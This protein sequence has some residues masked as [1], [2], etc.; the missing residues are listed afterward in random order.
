MLTTSYETFCELAQGVRNA[1]VPVYLER[2]AD[3]ETPVSVLSRFAAD[4]AVASL[5]GSGTVHVASLA[6]PTVG[7]MRGFSGSLTGAGTVTV[8][9][10]ATLDRSRVSVAD[11]LTVHALG[12]G[13]TVIIR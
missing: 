8:E 4:E 6:S 10:G 9:K 13:M 12:V 2:L 7:D 11:T 1:I 5:S 3:V